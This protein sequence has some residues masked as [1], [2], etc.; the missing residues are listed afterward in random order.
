MRCLA[1]AAA[2]IGAAVAAGDAG[3]GDAAT[4]AADADARAHPTGRIDRIPVRRPA[5]VW[6]P[7]G[8]FL[9]GLSPRESERLLQ[10]CSVELGLAARACDGSTGYP[11]PPLLQGTHGIGVR[12]VFVGAFRIDRHEVTSAEFRACVAAGACDVAALVS[13]EPAYLQS[14]WPMVNVGWQDAVD[15]C[16]WR[17]K[18]LPTEAEWERAARGDDGRRWPWGDQDRRD[19]ANTGQS[20]SDVVKLARAEQGIVLW[21]TAPD[22]RDGGLYALPPGTLHWGE[23]PYGTLDQA[24]NVAEWVT[25]YFSADGYRGLSRINPVRELPPG[26]EKRRVVRGGDWYSPRHL[27]RTYVR[28]GQGPETRLPWVGFRCAAEAR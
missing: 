1:L 24:G 6:V 10:A 23:G 21:L 16:A 15:Y 26:A 27:A 13:G 2:L 9:I 8:H 18:R 4:G 28:R 19:G 3:A 14:T 11:L 25:D 20:E 22:D 7:A 5:M 12:E 17:G